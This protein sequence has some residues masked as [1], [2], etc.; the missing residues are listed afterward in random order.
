MWVA[1]SHRGEGVAS[2]LVREVVAWARQSRSAVTHL[3]VTES[4]QVARRLYERCGFT[5]LDERQPLPSNPD[6][7]ELRMVHRGNR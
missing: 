3:W 4:N 6:L 1:P 5:Y 7:D 2:R